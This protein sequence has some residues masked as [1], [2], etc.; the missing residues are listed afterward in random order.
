MNDEL[1]LSAEKDLH[2]FKKMSPLHMK[3][4]KITQTIGDTKGLVCL[5][6]GM[7][8]SMQSYGLRKNG[9]EWH[10]VVSDGTDIEA[11]KEVL[12]DNVD[13]FDG[14]TL[15]F[16]DK[17]FNIVVVSD[18][19]ERLSSS[20]DFIEE[21]HRILR[22]DGRLIITVARAKSCS[23]IGPLR[24]L[25]GVTDDGTGRPYCAYTESRLFYI[26]KH[27]FNV[28]QVKSY[29]RF[30]VEFTHAIVSFFA[31]HIDAENLDDIRKIKRLYS[32][33]GPF[34]EL[35]RQVDM[36]LFF[37]TGHIFVVTAVRRAWLSRSTPVLSDG[38]TI[39]E[40]VLSKTAR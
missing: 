24:N 21:C 30:F 10:T 2:L 1:S 27:G 9:G 28:H 40:A 20:D 12:V 38:R 13:L 29:S 26:L 23:L 35:A 4:R 3:L 19:L 17:T 22:P 14:I 25:L 15:P 33:A 6:V 34:Y 36:L 8:N 31:D 5:D 37:N 16:K 11:F 7:L 18:C 39:S 32:I